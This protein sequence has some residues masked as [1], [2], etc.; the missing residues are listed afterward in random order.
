M[1]EVAVATH[2]NLGSHWSH[3]DGCLSFESHPSQ[4]VS[5]LPVLRD[6]S[7][8][9][10]LSSRLPQFFNQTMKAY[11][12]TKFTLSAIALLAA[13]FVNWTIDPLWY[14]KGNRLTGRNFTFNERVSKTNL[15]S[16]SNPENYDCIIFGSSRV[17]LLKASFLEGERCFN[18]AFSAG[19]VEEFVEYAK[20]AKAQGVNPKKV[21]VGIDAFNFYDPEVPRET[22]A[23]VNIQPA[24]KA[25]F[26]LDVVWFS[27]RTLLGISPYPRYYNENFESDVIKNLPEFK[28]YLL[29]R[30][31]QGTC[32]ASK[33][34]FYEEL[35]EIFPKAEFIGYVPPIS[36]WNIYNDLYSRNLMDCYFESMYYL[37]Q[38]FDA[39]Y[40]FSAPSTI[41][42]T[43]KNTY[44][45]DH[46]YPEIHEKI[47]DIMQGKA[48]DFGIRV[49]R[50]SFADY[51]DFYMTR[52]EKFIERE[53]KK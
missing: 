45:G 18:Y 13:G 32:E 11:L 49:D 44:D 17:T 42:A 4:R 1:A 53:R 39:T 25:Y 24:Y 2:T 5:L 48:S 15:L 14:G 31:T 3:F 33:V 30:N 16:R 21:Y 23:V 29:E 19:R 10:F 36:P 52:M 40:D 34:K 28:P 47:A 7:P 8:V 43:P 50:H 38:Q 35:R 26:S 41:T 20:H 12:K 6:I 37:S 46:Y 51:R 22:V 9:S 27:T